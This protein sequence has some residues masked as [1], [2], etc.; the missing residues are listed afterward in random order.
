MELLVVFNRLNEVFVVV[1][2]MCFVLGVLR[3]DWPLE[4]RYLFSYC[5]LPFGMLQWD[6]PGAENYPVGLLHFIAETWQVGTRT[7][8]Q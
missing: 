3:G 1:D 8:S 6:L 2:I 5:L 4:S 7:L